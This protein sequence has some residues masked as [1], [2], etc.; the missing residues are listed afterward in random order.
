MLLSCATRVGIRLLQ[1]QQ[2]LHRCFFSFVSF[3]QIHFSFP[4]TNKQSFTTHSHHNTPTNNKMSGRGKEERDSEG[5]RQAPPKVLGTTS[6]ASP[7]RDPPSGTQG[8]RQAH[9]WPHLRGDPRPQGVPRERHPRCGHVHRAR[10]PQDGH[11]HGR[12]LRSQAPR[13]HALRLRP[14]RIN[15][16]LCL[17]T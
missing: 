8:W 14:K 17:S 1:T 7:A 12:R 4:T 3:L 15:F 10:P 16:S 9:L 2:P 11:G 13:T 6:R 5:R